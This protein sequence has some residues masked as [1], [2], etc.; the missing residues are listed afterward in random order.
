[1]AARDPK[2]RSRNASIAADVK[3]SLTPNRAEGTAA[4]RRATP[5]QLQYWITWAK[6]KHPN[7][8][9][10]QQIKAAESRWRAH[11]KQLSKKAAETRRQ[12]AAEAAAKANQSAA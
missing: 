12:R 2:V 11:Q 6:K 1:M 3:W 9:H 10:A 7:A 5:I 4:A 8:T